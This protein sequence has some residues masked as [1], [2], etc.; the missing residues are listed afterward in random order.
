MP[1]PAKPRSS[2]VAKSSLVRESFTA[3][4]IAARAAEVQ[5]SKEGTAPPLDRRISGEVPAA[6]LTLASREAAE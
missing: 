4:L 1:A 2:L 6:V 3:A 5:F